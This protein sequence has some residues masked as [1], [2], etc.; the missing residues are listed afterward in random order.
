MLGASP[1]RAQRADLPRECR[2]FIGFA[3]GGGVDLMGRAIATRLG[4]RTSMRISVEDRTGRWGAIPGE[5]LKTNPVGSTLA[6]LSSKI[7]RAHV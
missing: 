1:S 4:M 2:I 6:F 7:G 5:L 3:A